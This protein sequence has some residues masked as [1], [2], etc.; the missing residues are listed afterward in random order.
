MFCR[1]R[2]TPLVDDPSGEDEGLGDVGGE[3]VNQDTR[4]KPGEYQTAVPVKGA[5]AGDK[6]LVVQPGRIG[7]RHIDEEIAQHLWRAGHPLPILLHARLD[8]PH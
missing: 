4:R 6:R 2:R 5:D 8:E 7:R 3:P 1:S